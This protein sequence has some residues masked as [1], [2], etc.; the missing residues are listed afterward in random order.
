MVWRTELNIWGLGYFWS[1]S[2]T[3]FF[4]LVCE[5]LEV[6]NAVILHA[7]RHVADI[8]TLSNVELYACA[9]SRYVSRKLALFKKYFLTCLIKHCILSFQSSQISVFVCA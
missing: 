1:F 9:A 7:N 4:A 3:D 2:F 6:G 8:F 5:K